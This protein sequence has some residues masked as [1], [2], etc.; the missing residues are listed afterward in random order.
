MSAMYTE[1]GFKKRRLDL[2][3]KASEYALERT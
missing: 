1:R 2:Q 3:I